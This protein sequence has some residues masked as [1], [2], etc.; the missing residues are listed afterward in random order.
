MNK[1]Y[2]LKSVVENEDYFAEKVSVSH[3]NIT[4][5]SVE[6]ISLIDKKI[7]IELKKNKGIVKN[8]IENLYGLPIVS[9]LI[10][11]TI[12]NDNFNDVELIEVKVSMK[13]DLKYYLLNILNVFDCIDL[14][15]SVY[16]LY[17]PDII[18][19]D[20]IDKLVID[21]TKIK[22][23][24]FRIKGLLLEI[25]VSEQL[26]NKLENLKLSEIEFMPIEDFTKE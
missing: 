20:S 25:I 1:Y 3:T 17:V 15:K 10:A 12:M 21:T 22:N 13:T 23:D 26:K 2:I 4:E 9:E 8:Y 7:K 16:K 5:L 14:E 18:L 19:F 24:I 11:E 6:G